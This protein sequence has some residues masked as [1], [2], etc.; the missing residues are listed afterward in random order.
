MKKIQKIVYLITGI[1]T[2]AFVVV[3]CGSDDLTEIQYKND[4]AVSDANRMILDLNWDAYEN[5]D[6]SE[7]NATKD[8]RS[9][10][11]WNNRISIQDKAIQVKLLADKLSGAGGIVTRT[12]IPTSNEYRLSFDVRF[13]DD[14]D[15]SR[16]GKVGFGFLM[17]DGNTGCDKADDGNGG[18]ARMM[19]YTG[20]NGETKF[21]PY[22]YYNDMPDACGD[23][24]ISSAAYPSSGSIEKGKWYTIEI[25]VKSNTGNN[26]DGH[27]TYKVDNTVVLD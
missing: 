25:Y 22:L 26:K 3:S 8:F 1:L 7:A 16:G 18:S 15:W 4:G 24:L 10:T 20:N 14:F 5:G 12:S 27:V 17:G 13:A 21:K 9:L 23:S 11:Q 2:L 6:Y 19:W